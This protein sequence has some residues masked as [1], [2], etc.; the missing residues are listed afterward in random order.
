MNRRDFL[1]SAATFAV[2]AIVPAFRRSANAAPSDRI[3]MGIVGVG[4]QGG[5]HTRFLSGYPGVQVVAVCDVD[6]GRCQKAVDRV[7]EAYGQAEKD[8]KHKGCA[9][10]GDFR[11]LVARPDIDAVL[12]ATPDHWHAGI[13]IAAMEAGK[14]CYIEKPLS[15]TVE[16]GRSIADAARRYRRVTQVGSHERSRPTVRYACE[17]VR[18]AR[19]GKLHTI[20]V[21][22]PVDTNTQKQLPPQPTMPVPDGLNWDM[23]LGPSPWAPYT[24]KRCHFSFRYVMDTA[25]GEMTD[26][27]AHV[28]D[29]AQLGN[30]SENIGPVEV[31]G[32]GWRPPEGLFD[33]FMKY[34]FRMRYANDVELIGSSKGPRGIRFEGSDGWVFVHIH[35][36]RLEASNPSLLKEKIGPDEV[37][38]GRS[39]GHHQDFLNAVRTR[40]TT[41]APAEIGH[42]SVTLC[43]LVNIALLTGKKLTWDPAAERVTNC[44][45]ASRML[46][47]PPR[48]PWRI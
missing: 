27:G 28:L 45:Q 43:H 26:R 5:Y 3:V 30:G 37:H 35:G 14:D 9:G 18:N 33:T 15:L 42:R 6:A 38:L 32:T 13:A 17:L 7:N 34:D 24:R 21:G 40:G 47:R 44:D 2:P 39:P 12:T 41:M 20:R 11:E 25:G 23:W 46:G 48:E 19:I 16:Q 8:G 31:E 22:M 10:Y 1:R 4:G 36:G 29:I